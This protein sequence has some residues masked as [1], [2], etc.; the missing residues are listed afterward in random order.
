MEGHHEV[1]FLTDPYTW[2]TLAFLLVVVFGGFKAVKGISAALDKRAGKISDELDEAQ[3]LREEAQ[4]LLA[5]YQ[6]KQREA[7]KEADEIRAHAKA[8]ADRMLETAEA[9]L[10]ASLKRREQQAMDR[11]ANL[12]AQAIADVRAH[13]AEVATQATTALVSDKV[14]GAKADEL[15]N[16]AIA[17]IKGHLN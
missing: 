1:T 16:S 6:A 10:N 14:S 8:E 12:E 9:E 11:I 17:E 7:L 2:T 3:R 5:N 15:V 13:V 4:E